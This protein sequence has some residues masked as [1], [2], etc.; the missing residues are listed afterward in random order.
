MK[1]RPILLSSMA[2]LLAGCGKVADLE[3]VADHGLPQKPA[4]AAKTP[5]AEDLLTFPPYAKPDRIDELLRKGEKRKSDRFDLPPSSGAPA[6]DVG[7]T[8]DTNSVNNQT[9]PQELP[10]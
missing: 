8:P 4:M 10:L 3:P 6:P 7:T 2:L 1:L 5:S 9:Q